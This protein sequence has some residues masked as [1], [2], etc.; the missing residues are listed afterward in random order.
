MRRA[1]VPAGLSED[2]TSLGGA[3]HFYTA[4]QCHSVLPLYIHPHTWLYWG[5]SHVPRDIADC[6]ITGY[7]ASAAL[8]KNSF[9]IWTV[10]GARKRRGILRAVLRGLPPER[11]GQLG[12]RFEVD[13]VL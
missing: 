4:L 11:K 13:D 8:R 1:T 5:G 6:R 3:A 10:A 7:G 9:P 2:S 12:A